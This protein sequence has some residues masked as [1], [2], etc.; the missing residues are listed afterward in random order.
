MCDSGQ[1]GDEFH[2]CLEC[3]DLKELGNKFL[4]ADIYKRL[5]VIN[6]GRILSIKNKIT[7]V[8]VAKFIK[9]GLDICNYYLLFVRHSVLYIRFGEINILYLVR[10]HNYN[11]VSL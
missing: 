4:P 9:F 11:A 3:P 6:F 1:L 7:L 5:N 2:F 8:N 10:C